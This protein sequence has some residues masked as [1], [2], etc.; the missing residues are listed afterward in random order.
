MSLRNLTAVI[1]RCDLGI[2]ELVAAPFASGLSVLVDDERELGCTVIDMGGGTTQMAVF[3]D[4]QLLH[5]AQ[6]PVGGLHVT[7]DIAQVL[8]DAAGQAP[9]G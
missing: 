4:N 3:A 5:T 7:K 9:S 1:A 2:T 8:S 6:L